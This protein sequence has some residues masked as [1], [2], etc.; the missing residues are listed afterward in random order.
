MYCTKNGGNVEN[1]TSEVQKGDLRKVFTER[2]RNVPRSEK[3][4]LLWTGGLGVGTVA[5]PHSGFSQ[6]SVRTCAPRFGS[7]CF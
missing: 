6:G 1:G 4:K 3:P 5:L 7:H 2:S